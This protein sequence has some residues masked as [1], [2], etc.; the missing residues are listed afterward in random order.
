[1]VALTRSW[2]PDMQPK[3]TRQ[4]MTQKTRLRA[5]MMRVPVFREMHEQQFGSFGRETIFVNKYLKL[6]ENEI[7]PGTKFL[8]GTH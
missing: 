2:D 4:R 8:E 5:P 1:M 6:D 7:N 3:E